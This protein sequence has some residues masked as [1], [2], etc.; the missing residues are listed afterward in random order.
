[1]K[2][3]L[4]GASGFI[5]TRLAEA[6]SQ[7]H[8]VSC[9]L[10]STPKNGLEKL[11]IRTYVGSFEDSVFLQKTLVSHDAIIHCAGSAG[12]W[13]SKSF[14]E[15]SNLEL[16][17]RL[18]QAA[19]EA[20]IK[21]WIQISTPS[22]YFE[23]KNQK[24]ISEDFLPKTLSSHYAESKLA[25][26]LY[27][28]SQKN[29]NTTILRPRFVLGRGDQQILP[30]IL[31]YMKKGYYPLIGTGL[32]KIDVTNITNLC[33]AVEKALLVNSTL[34]GEVYNVSNGEPITLLELIEE[35]KLHCGAPVKTIK[36]P[37]TIALFAAK[38]FEGLHALGVAPQNFWLHPLE[39]AVM[40]QDMTL[41]VDKIKRDLGYVPEKNFR[42]A[43]AE[44]FEIQKAP[45]P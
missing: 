17:K 11:P 1:M 13:G 32:Q 44:Y 40:T 22:I 18:S 7:K 34:S 41:N 45:T 2:I 43:I 8:Y 9:L 6:L 5:G 20:K 26:D 21:K 25:A 24:N 4:T 16:T 42:S 37:K 39:V 15:K 19:Q 35:I 29:L 23:F 30:R 28:L 10:R 38:V 27:L 12:T 36:I 14:Y 33:Q 3:L 31:R